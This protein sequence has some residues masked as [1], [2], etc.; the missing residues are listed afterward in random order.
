M[1]KIKETPEKALKRKKISFDFPWITAA[2]AMVVLVVALSLAN[3]MFLS[4]SNLMSILRQAAVYVIMGLGMSFVMM[5]GGV[6]LSQGSLLALIGV[7]SAYIVQNVGSIPLAI[8]A[9]VIV[10]A[11]IGSI[12][13]SIISCLNIPPFIATLASMYLC[14]GL[15]LVI[16]QA[17][18][19][20]L[21]NEAF[22]WIGT[23]SLLGLPVPVYIFLIAAAA[24]QFILSYTATGRFILAVGSNQEAARLS[25]IKTRWNKCKAYILSGIM[26]S[27]A[28]IVYV[29]RLGAAQATAG[30]SY[31]MEAIAAAVLGGTSVMGGE[32]TVFGTVLGAIVVA[33]VRNA[34]VL[35]EISTYYQQIVTGAVILIAVIIDTQRKAR[36]AKRVD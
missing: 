5:T 6:D 3:P 2:I 7:I 13:G 8:L 25:G 22:K 32:G 33:I 14:R 19:I 36:A 16:T 1:E 35:L 29:S 18:P 11:V 34:M 20:V 21:T 26:V 12:N 4:T 17:S 27:I 15:T 31:E 9:S 24:G 28:G 23:G 30:Q 10:G